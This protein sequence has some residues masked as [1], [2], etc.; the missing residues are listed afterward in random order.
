MEGAR[1]TGPS[2][3][4][5]T[6]TRMDFQKLRQHAQGLNMSKEDGDPVLTGELDTS[7]HP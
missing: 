3:Y 5:R 2:R 4:S 7:T 6:D 1:E